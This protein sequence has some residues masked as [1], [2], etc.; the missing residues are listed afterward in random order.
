M[1]KYLIWDAGGTLFDTY[2]AVVQACCKALAAFGYTASPEW[3]LTLAKQSTAMC[4]ATLAET[5]ALEEETLQR[6]FRQAY[7]EIELHL[8]PPFPNVEE[9][10]RY[11]CEI[12]GKNFIVT[13]RSRASLEGLLE[14]HGMADYFADC[15]VKE[16]PYPR[17]PEPEAINVLLTR[18]A[19]D[20]R[21]CLLIGDRDL[22]ILAG[23]RAGVRTCFFGAGP[24]DVQADIEIKDFATLLQWL[25]AE[26]EGRPAADCSTEVCTTSHDST[27]SRRQDN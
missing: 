7:E 25:Q 12:G 1:I 21:Q 16:D 13:H 9:V 8:Q 17:K 15:I 11:I 22:D 20:R 27:I 24:H 4:L 26:N 5:F 2:P 10:C 18:H 19:V 23:Q 3:I 6:H 14:A